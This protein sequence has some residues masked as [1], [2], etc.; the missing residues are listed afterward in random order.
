MADR[1]PFGDVASLES[2]ADEVWAA[3]DREDRLE[4]FAAHPRIGGD[5]PERDVGGHSRRWSSDEQSGVRDAD[6]DALVEVN[7]AYEERFGWIFLICAT[8]LDST[9]ILERARQRLDNDPETELEVAA[10]EQR[11]ITRL[12]IDKLLGRE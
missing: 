12:R 7:R 3:L 4:A 8:G 5:R 10:E 1:R 2:A 11:R 6:R 9:T